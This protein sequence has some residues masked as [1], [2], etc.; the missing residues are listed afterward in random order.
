MIEDN[1][2]PSDFLHYCAAAVFAQPTTFRG[3]LG[4]RL[5]NILEH[6]PHQ[7]PRER[8]TLR[9]P[10]APH[11]LRGL[12]TLLRHNALKG[13]VLVSLL[14]SLIPLQSQQQNR[15]I[16]LQIMIV[17]GKLFAPV[18]PGIVQRLTGRDGEGDDGKRW[19]LGKGVDE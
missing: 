7:L 1:P 8:T 5:G 14:R 6:F 2:N 12:Q 4:R 16:M 19:L 10:V 13:P 3:R 17:Q 11:L 9:I 15:N 18:I